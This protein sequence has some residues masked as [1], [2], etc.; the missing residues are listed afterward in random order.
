MSAVDGDEDEDDFN[1]R[2]RQQKQMR[3]FSLV[4]SV[5]QIDDDD[6]ELRL[7]Q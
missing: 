1:V 7:A 5:N 3:D 4:A 6:D 2:R